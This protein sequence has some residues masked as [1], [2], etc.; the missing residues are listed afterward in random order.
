VDYIHLPA[1]TW[2]GYEESFVANLPAVLTLSLIPIHGKSTSVSSATVA[3]QDQILWRHQANV[4]AK[5]WTSMFFP[6]P[7]LMP[8]G[9]SEEAAL[10]AA[11]EA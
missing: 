10:K 11:N 2:Y 4:S 5:T 1:P 9:G 7:F 8:G 6:T 3:W